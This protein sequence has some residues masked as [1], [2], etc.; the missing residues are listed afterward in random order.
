MFKRISALALILSCFSLNAQINCDNDTTFRIPIID[1]Q[2]GYY[3]SHQGGLYPGGSNIM[4]SAHADSGLTI[5]QSLMPINFDGELDTTYGKFVFLALGNGSAG[6]IFNKFLTQ[7]E[8]LGFDDSCMQIVNACIDGYSLH[9]MYGADADF[10]WDDVNDYLQDRDLKKKQVR[11]VWLMTSNYDD[12]LVTE[13]A[14]IDSVK[15]TY[16]EVIQK[17]KNQLPNLALLYISGLQY[18]GYVDTSADIKHFV[19]EPVPYLNDLAIKAVIEAQIDGDSALIY[20]GPDTEAPWIAWGPNVW[21]DGRNLRAYDNLRWICPSDYDTGLNGFDLSSTGQVKV[22]DRL[23]TFCTTEPTIL[24]W[25]YGLPYDCFTEP[26][27]VEPEDSLIIPEGEVL[28]ITQNPV[29]GVIKFVINIETNEKAQI[30]VFDMIGNQIVEGVFNKI[31]PG[32]VLDINMENAARGIYVLSVFVENK[33]Y[34][35]MFYLDN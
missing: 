10:Y 35:R 15:N 5:A 21:A 18:G 26:D 32:R 34:N 25:I 23:F 33:V 29:K 19:T 30:Y 22:A 17:M 24:P 7:Y 13:D 9:D 11:A 28:W 12:T 1:L 14:Y 8:D 4:P 16:I 20:S 6:K 31:E 2:T 3:G 27:V